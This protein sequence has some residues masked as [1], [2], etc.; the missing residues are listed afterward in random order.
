MIQVVQNFSRGK[1][2]HSYLCQ[3]RPVAQDQCLYAEF[4]VDHI[5]DTLITSNLEAY[6][7]ARIHLHLVSLP[8]IY[9][10]WTSSWVARHTSDYIGAV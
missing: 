9:L 8:Q 4:S 7:Q 6:E 1:S 10:R 5:A 2:K 3:C